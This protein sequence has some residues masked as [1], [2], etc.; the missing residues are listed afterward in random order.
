LN[1][2]LD[3]N[4]TL[5]H[6]Q[7][8]EVFSIKISMRGKKMQKPEKYVHCLIKVNIISPV[9]QSHLQAAFCNIYGHYNDLVCHYNVPIGQLLSN[10]LHTY[11]VLLGYS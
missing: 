11:S 4:S 8:S 6:P 5:I 10:M 3:I 9:P 1:L 7:E 2:G